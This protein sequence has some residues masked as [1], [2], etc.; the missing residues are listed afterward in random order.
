MRDPLGAEL[1]VRVDVGVRNGVAIY[2]VLPGSQ[3]P[4][5]VRIAD[6]SRR[7]EEYPQH[8]H[9]FEQTR[10]GEIFP[11]FQHNLPTATFTSLASAQPGLYA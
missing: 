2:D 10:Y 4:P 11:Q 6:T 5:E 8:D 3:V 9:D 7:Q 1:G